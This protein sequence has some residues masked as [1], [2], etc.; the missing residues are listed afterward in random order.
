MTRSCGLNHHIYAALILL[1]DRQRA[2]RRLQQRRQLRL[3]ETDLLVWI[4]HMAQR[5]SHVQRPARL[6]FEK[7]VV[8]T[9][10]NLCRLAGGAQLLQVPVTELSL[11]VLLVANRLRVCDPL[12][13][14]RGCGYVGSCHSWWSNLRNDE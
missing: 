4:A 3:H 10:M 14:G 5:R 13:D 7:H 11:F 2:A 8:A 12:G 1:D 9:Q 6:A